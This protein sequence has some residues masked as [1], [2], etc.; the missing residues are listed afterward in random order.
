[1]LAA[2]LPV[3]AAGCRGAALSSSSS[4]APVPAVALLP[5]APCL[6]PRSAGLTGA[7]GPAGPSSGGCPAGPR[8]SSCGHGRGR[9]SG[10]RGSLLT[11]RAGL[12]ELVYAEGYRE[13]EEI[14]GVRL[15]VEGDDPRVEYLT[16]WKVGAGV[17]SVGAQRRQW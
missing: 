12:G 15:V 7:S 8:S 1:M 17:G 9:A 16:K 11:A 14:C 6:V 4:R 10:A 2:K 13:V 5:A 3:A